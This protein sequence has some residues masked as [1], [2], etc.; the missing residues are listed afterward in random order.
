VIF[1]NTSPEGILFMPNASVFYLPLDK[2]GA[3]PNNRV[4]DEI[5]ITPAT[6]HRLILPKFGAF[7]AAS[8]E[9]YATV[10]DQGVFTDVLLTKGVDYYPAE[11]LHKT[12]AMVGK[13]VCAT[14][15]VSEPNIY[16]NF[17][18]TYSA[19]GG[20]DQVNR[21]NLLALVDQVV[22]PSTIYQ[23]DDIANKP[24]G[25]PPAPHL[26]DADDLYGLEY[27][28]DSLQRLDEAIVTGD[29]QAHQT[30]IDKI[31]IS[32][33][34][35]MDG[36]N[37]LIQDKSDLTMSLVKS[38]NDTLDIVG[39]LVSTSNVTLG[40]VSTQIN[41]LNKY[42]NDYKAYNAYDKLANVANLLCKIRY[43]AGMSR[44]DVPQ[45]FEGLE[46]YLD[47]I[48]YNPTT[49]VW[50]DKRPGSGGYTN[51]GV[52]KPTHAFSTSIPGMKC[53]KF[54]N[55]QFLSR[56]GISIELTKNKT[57]ITVLGNVGSA[58]GIKLPLFNDDTRQLLVDTDNQ[59]SY[60]YSHSNGN[61][62]LAFLAK[63]NP[64]VS[65]SVVINATCIGGRDEDCYTLNS[66]PVTGSVAPS[67]IDQNSLSL[68]D[69]D[70]SALRIGSSAGTQSCEVFMVLVYD[71]ILSRAQMHA[72]MTYLRMKYNTNT[73]A[74]V[75][76]DFS[77]W[78]EGFGSDYQNYMDLVNRGAVTVTDRN[79]VAWDP[80]GTY[81]QPGITDPYAIKIDNNPYLLVA[82]NDANKAFYRQTM[83][84]DI[85]CRHE[86]VLSV[87]Y[88]QVSPPVIRLKVNG[89]FIPGSVVLVSGQSI[90]RDFVFGFV[91]N[92]K[93]NTIELVN[94]NTA[95]VGN[96]FGVGAMRLT[97]K[98]YAD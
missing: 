33:Q 44:P 67:G 49:G 4:E 45:L 76:G 18:I 28:V 73:N 98:I 91:P 46:L 61:T 92:V 5:H 24:K 2:T 32:K 64:V 59:I 27:I 29:R 42:V 75:N 41:K 96:V 65:G 16:T 3:N 62:G 55:G 69:I 51:T 15:L 17:K 90:V 20:T 14:I 1:E 23:W 52:S 82:S 56:D 85:Y 60:K 12:T 13:Q 47:S 34:G 78:D 79:I 94:T 19:L 72:I 7:Y 83:N 50:T 54:E 36:Y 8:V 93:V 25:F 81:S 66:S 43:D 95:S 68:D 84:L 70:S 30:L 53:V 77:R 9:V 26:Q 22:N 57:V 37:P 87:V 58:T 38:A 10:Q 88:N 40:T 86:F 6:T 71:R 74:L 63:M 89:V 11:M 80:T 39:D 97:R 31:E 21:D 35:V 48:Q